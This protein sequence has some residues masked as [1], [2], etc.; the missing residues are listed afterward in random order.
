VT[1]AAYDDNDGDPA[2]ATT[3]C[4]VDTTGDQVAVQPPANAGLLAAT[5]GV[6]AGGDAGVDVHYAADGPGTDGRG[7][8]GRGLAALKVNGG[9]RLYRVGLLTGRARLVGPFPAHQQVTDL[10]AGFRKDELRGIRQ[11]QC[12]GTRLC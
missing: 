10:T 6:D 12:H 4:T 3:L 1:G 9:Y 5:L 2:T 11:G 8:D 7:A